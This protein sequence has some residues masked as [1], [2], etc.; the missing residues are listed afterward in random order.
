MVNAVENG[1]KR[2]KEKATPSTH[3][4]NRLT[5]HPP[6]LH[7]EI[8]PPAH[9]TFPETERRRP[10]TRSNGSGTM[11]QWSDQ[12]IKWRSA[13]VMKRYE[14]AKLRNLRFPHNSERISSSRRSS[15][16]NANTT[17]LNGPRSRR[18]L[19]RRLS[20][21]WTK[22]YAKT[23][24]LAN[25]FTYQTNIFAYKINRFTYKANTSTNKTNTFT[26]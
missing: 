26:Y 22:S 14:A 11:M 15:A 25:T 23:L 19:G 10:P 9:P 13:L 8:H 3:P 6:N 4:P 1:E 12:V 7:S 17:A 21:N 20:S 16:P 24:H 2:E 5:A 18:L